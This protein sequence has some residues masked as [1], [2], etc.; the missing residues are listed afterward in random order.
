[1]ANIKKIKYVEGTGK[2]TVNYE[3]FNEVTGKMDSFSINT[4]AVPS[5]S[6]VRALREG[7]RDAHIVLAE[8]PVAWRDAL[9]TTGLTIDHK[10]E[11]RHVNI[12]SWRSLS[13]G[14]ISNVNGPSR[15]IDAELDAGTP[16][17]VEVADAID[18]V[19]R[20][21]DEFIKGRRA[22]MEL[23]TPGENPHGARTAKGL[24]WD[25]GREGEDATKN[26]FNPSE[27]PDAHES[28]ESGWCEGRQIWDAIHSVGKPVP[29]LEEME[30]GESGEGLDGD[31]PSFLQPPSKKKGRKA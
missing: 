11:H 13:C 12:T 28:W 20:E 17:M 21:A 6:F 8:L 14:K 5:P 25:A 16:G 29:T 1:M 9:T 19:L 15:D 27:D 10:K 2:V 3:Q 4:E 24:G 26:P 7:L 30:D 18:A 22:Q 31:E 23:P